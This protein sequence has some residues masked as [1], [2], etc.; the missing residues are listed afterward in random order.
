M[1][2][3]TTHPRCELLRNGNE[4][5]V[6]LLLENGADVNPHSPHERCSP[7]HDASKSGHE[8]VVRILLEKGPNVDACTASGL[9]AMN[10]AKMYWNDQVVQLLPWGVKGTWEEG[11]KVPHRKMQG[12]PAYGIRHSGSDKVLKMGPCVKG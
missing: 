1:S 2:T 7:R 10:L 5:V 11:W 8:Q 9:T 12:L 6:R 3:F 4:R